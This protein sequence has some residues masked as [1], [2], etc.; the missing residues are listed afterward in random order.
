MIKVTRLDGREIFVNADMIEFIEKTPDT[1]LR[2]VTGKN[3]M[4]REDIEEVMARYTEYRRRHPVYAV[5][6][7]VHGEEMANEDDES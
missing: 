3:M 1:I 5:Y 6:T 4:V 7:S 2:F